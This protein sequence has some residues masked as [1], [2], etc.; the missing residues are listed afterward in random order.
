MHPDSPCSPS[1]VE[2]PMPPAPPG[3]AEALCDDMAATA[4]RL[5]EVL[6]LATFKVGFQSPTDAR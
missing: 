4:E 2:S 3:L 1:A 6:A 5:E